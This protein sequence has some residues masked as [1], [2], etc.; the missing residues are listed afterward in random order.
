MLTGLTGENRAYIED[1]YAD[2][3]ESP[4]TVNPEWRGIFERMGP[5]TGVTRREDVIGPAPNRRSIFGGREAAATAHRAEHTRKNA[6]VLQLISNYR[7]IGHLAADLD[8]LGLRERARLPQLGLAY[9]GLSD[10]DLETTFHV[11]RLAGP[12]Y[13][14]LR[15]VVERCE[16]I[17]CRS[18]AIEYAYIR[19]EARRR[20]LERRIEE[21]ESQVELDRPTALRVL[22]KM[23]AADHLETFIQ[24]KYL[25]QKRFSVEGGE[26]VI[27]LLDLIID[28]AAEL[29]ARE[30]VIGMA[31]R[32]RLNVLA[33]ILGKS[34]QDIFEEFDDAGEAHDESASGDVKYHLGFSS[35]TTTASGHPMHLSLAFN[36]SHLEFVAPVVMGQVRAKQ[37]HFKDTERKRALPIVIHG[38]AA[39]A[40]QGVSVETINLGRLDGYA[41]GGSIHVIINNQIGFTTPPESS[42]S[43]AHC[44]DV[45]KVILPPVLHVNADDLGAVAFTARLAGEYRQT[46]GE[47]IFIDLWCYR[48]YGHNEG[49]EPAFTNP[50]MVQAIKRRKTPLQ[51]FVEQAVAKGVLTKQDLDEVGGRIRAELQQALDAARSDDN[52][53]GLAGLWKGMHHGYDPAALDRK[54]SVPAERLV[55]LTKALGAM[56][57][58][59]AAHRKI[60]KVYTDRVRMIEGEIGIDWGLGETLAFATLLREGY[61][62][63]ISGQDAGRGTFAHRHSVVHDQNTGADWVPLNHL[64]AKQA[65]FEVID[66]PLSEAAVLGFDYGYSLV[67][68]D[69]LAIWEAQFGDFANGAQVL[70]DQFVCSS[71]AK[72]GRSSGL[73]MLLPHGYEGM[74]PEHSSARLER[75]LQLSGDENWRVMNLTTP[76]QIFH[77]LRGQLHRNY[78]KPLVVMTPKSL[79]KHRKAVSTLSDFTDGGF[80]PVI[81]DSRVSD[82]S[83][84]ERVVLCSGKVY[85]ELVQR[86]DDLGEQRIAVLRVEQLYPLPEVELKAALAEYPANADLVWCQEEP[87]NMGAWQHMMECVEVS[88]ERRPRYIGRR[89]SASPATGSKKV[90]KKEQ[91][92]LVEEATTL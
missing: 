57:E 60:K 10:D 39:I 63:R 70:I 18:V 72:W 61:A 47:D 29:G 55:E 83:K 86:L 64:G 27:P 92:A 7:R 88:T 42:R 16:R 87:R 8:P 54:T 46:F 3:V 81:D 59:H 75:F 45:A 62:V 28:T 24:T 9:H 84:V 34:A 37:D 51:K 77:A 30:T 19:D 5:P 71:E 33:N 4:V 6:A 26:A 58:S 41:V 31:H 68:P 74:G 78:R 14:T 85:Y 69:A 73:V 21:A 76:A 13:Q 91:S 20:W 38:D 53:E 44:T 48:K 15:E 90:H 50:V 79:L 23:G 32:G 17:Y 56:P 2:W 22:E 49:D 12:T 66:S 40:G 11:G 1:L 65:A 52:R 89:R 67:R 25:G 35:D 43:S 36:P 82:R 80:K